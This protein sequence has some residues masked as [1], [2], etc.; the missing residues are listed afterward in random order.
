MTIK[1][2]VYER[3]VQNVPAGRIIFSEGE[4]G[5]EL[6]VVIDGEVEISKRT[7]M[8]TSKTLITLKAG[9]IFGEM[10]I[11]DAKPRS[12]TA[13]ASKSARLLVMDEGLFF[14]MIEKNPDFARKMIRILSER[15]RRANLT[16][17]QLSSMNRES[18]ILTG[19][20]EY[21]ATFGVQSFKGKRVPKDKF[22]LWAESH[23]GLPAREIYEEMEKMIARHLLTPGANPG[24][25][26]LPS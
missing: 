22:V 23:I 2:D 7:S 20:A 6:Y 21:G 26:L 17:Q 16:I 1:K 5:K 11:I 18:M 12:A 3:H 4:E 9:D 13:I 15:I 8:E 25:I 19:I 10:A 24:E 14:N